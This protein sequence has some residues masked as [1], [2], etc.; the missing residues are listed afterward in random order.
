ML[1]LDHRIGELGGS[2]SDAVQVGELLGV[3]ILQVINRGKDAFFD[4][5]LGGDFY[6]INESVII[7]EHSICIGPA[8]INGEFF[9]R[10]LT[11]A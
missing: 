6:A 8:N 7:H 1:P 3:L 9:Q 4:I 2:E 5:E 11:I 10:G